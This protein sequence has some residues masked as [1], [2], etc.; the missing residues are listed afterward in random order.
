MQRGDA[1]AGSAYH[2]TPSACTDADRQ[3]MQDQ[4]QGGPVAHLHLLKLHLHM[5]RLSH[6]ATPSAREAD[7]RCVRG[8]LYESTLAAGCLRR[9]CSGFTVQRELPKGTC[10]CKSAKDI[11]LMHLV[12]CL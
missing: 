2:A 6:D 11:G 9:F 3:P 4:G 12:R 7:G 10:V 8:L 1:E 5:H